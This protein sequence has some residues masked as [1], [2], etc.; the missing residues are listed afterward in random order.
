MAITRSLEN[1]QHRKVDKENWRKKEICRKQR[2]EEDY[3]DKYEDSSL[4]SSSDK[5][6]YNK[7]SLDLRSSEKEEEERKRIK[8]KRKEEGTREDL[9]DDEGGVPLENKK[10]I[11]KP[12]WKS[13]AGGYLCGIRRYGSHATKNQ[14]IKCKKKLENPLLI[15]DWL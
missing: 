12:T 5:S 9:G 14:K 10:H 4:E 6:E 8:D 11:F 2:K 7:L 13:E 15:H 3:W 1:C